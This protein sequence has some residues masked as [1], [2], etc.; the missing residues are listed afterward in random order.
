MQGDASFGAFSGRTAKRLSGP[1][2]VSITFG[3]GAIEHAGKLPGKAEP[4]YH[5]AED[6]ARLR[7]AREARLAFAG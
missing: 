3:I 2:F 5:A 6:F 4:S 1:V 7:A